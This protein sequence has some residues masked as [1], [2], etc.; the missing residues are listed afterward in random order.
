MSQN[1]KMV[2]IPRVKKITTRVSSSEIAMET[3]EQIQPKKLQNPVKESQARMELHRELM[4]NQKIGTSPLSKKTELQKALEKIKCSKAA[5]SS[6]SP[7]EVSTDFDKILTE[8]K[9]YIDDN[10]YF[11]DK[12]N[13]L[14]TAEGTAAA[15]AR[16]ASSE[17]EKVHR[18]IIKKKEES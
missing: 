11:V 16:D 12:D 7:P 5:A 4:F 1:Q 10:H 3:E 6:S 15:A 17:F 8:R 18:K 2:I 14:A 13:N 9:R